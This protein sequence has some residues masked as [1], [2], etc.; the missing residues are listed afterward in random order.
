[1]HPSVALSTAN[2]RTLA[3]LFRHPTAHNLEWADMVALISAVGAVE[4]KHNSE[5]IFTV[6]GQRYLTRKPHGKDL[7]A[8]DVLELR[9]F[10]RKTYG[11]PD[12][13]VSEPKTPL[14]HDVLDVAVAID[15]HGARFYKLD[16]D[17]T[18]VTPAA[19]KPYDPYHFL[20]HLTHRDQTQEKGQRAPEDLTF[21]QRVADDL[22]TAR[23]IVVVGHGVGKSNAAHQL[24]DFLDARAPDTFRKIVRILDADLSHTSPHQLIEMARAV[25]DSLPV[26]APH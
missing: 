7:V 2:Q 9:T 4:Q 25:V 12:R 11:T 18:G 23:R 6:A 8:S 24:V 21:Y 15:H 26:P 16:A 17:S 1:M 3:A 10:V 13:P 22:S 20:H 5:V 19:V 14:H